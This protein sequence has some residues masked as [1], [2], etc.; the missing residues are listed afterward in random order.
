[1]PVLGYGLAVTFLK[2]FR[3]EAIDAGTLFVGFRNYF[4]VLG[5]M[6]LVGLYTFLW[7]LLFIV[8][9]I[10]KAY[11]YAMTAYILHDDLTVGADEAIERSKAMMNGY[12]AKLFLLDLSFIG[13]GLLCVLTLGIGLLWLIPYMQTSRAAFYEEVRNSAAVA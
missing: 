1:M 11:S 5:P 4:K 13:W 12:K 7:T 9:G 10:I 2:N 3:R 6:L 8:P